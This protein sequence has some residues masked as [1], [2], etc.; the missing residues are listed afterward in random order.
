[1]LQKIRR[2]R[3]SRNF[4]NIS[5]MQAGDIRFTFGSGGLPYQLGAC[6]RNSRRLLRICC[7]TLGTLIFPGCASLPYTFGTAESYFVSGELAARS[8]P[9]VERGQPRAV[10]DTLGWVWGIPGKI[11]LLD[12]RVENHRIDAVTEAEIAAYLADNEL[13]TVKV[14]LNQYHPAD[15]WQRL[16]A[17]KSVG[18]GW[19][20][21]LG[22]LSVLG[23]TVI[24]GRLFGGDHYNPFTNTIHLY[25][26]V[27]AIAIHEAGHARD[28]A[29]RKWK[30]TYAAAYLLPVVPLYH[31]AIATNDALGYIQ[32][33]RDTAAQREAYE[34]L[35]PAYG[36]YVGST[37]SGIVPFGYI[38]GV[39]GGH[40]CGQ[41]KSGT[42]QPD[43]EH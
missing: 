7:L 20:Y 10:I 42:L 14:R 2:C 36:T 37:V 35:Y 1:M 12:R 40:V 32:T 25:S 19:R 21:T 3:G 34:I 27:P 13:S 30:G 15:D 4:C 29:R 17:N 38:A 6:R 31:E 39:I 8:G 26:N 28:F 41:W 5:L 23:E 24:P 11:I 18:A 9:Q 22:T 16:V 43:P 33:T